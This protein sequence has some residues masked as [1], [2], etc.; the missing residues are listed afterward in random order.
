VANIT[1]FFVKHLELFAILDYCYELL[2][3]V[4]YK[5]NRS[6][7]MW[8][9]LCSKFSFT[10]DMI[11]ICSAVTVYVIKY[12]KNLQHFCLTFPLTVSYLISQFRLL[13][14]SKF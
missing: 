7:T 3:I 13:Y 5:D 4:T 8:L 11:L 14:A 1:I 12:F 6:N 10:D 9:Y 2:N